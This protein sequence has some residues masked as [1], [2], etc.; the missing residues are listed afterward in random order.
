MVLTSAIADEDDSFVKVDFELILLPVGQMLHSEVRPVVLWTELRYK[1]FLGN[2]LLS[3]SADLFLSTIRKEES[4]GEEVDLAGSSVL[5][6]DF[7]NETG[8]HGVYRPKRIYLV[9]VIYSPQV[10]YL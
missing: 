9:Y 6:D 8:S 2:G 1:C 3:I 7:E 10:S 4:A 5:A